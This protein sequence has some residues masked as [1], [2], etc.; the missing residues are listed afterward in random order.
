MN[1]MIIG[2]IM[3]LV[4]G[5]AFTNGVRDIADG[6][7]IAGSV[8]LLDAILVFVC[9]AAGVGLVITTY[10]GLTGGR[11]VMISELF[12]TTVIST[13]AA[14]AGTV[15]FALLVRRPAP[16]FSH[17]VESSEE[18]AGSSTACWKTVCPRPPQLFSRQCW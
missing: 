15:A 13:A 10:H 16:F 8:R 2:S 6:D 3:P 11:R 1:Y 14:A 12:L 5:I 9:I 18:R 17:T 4:P 7:Y